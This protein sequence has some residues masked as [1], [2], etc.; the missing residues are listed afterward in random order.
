M[1]KTSTPRFSA[2]QTALGKV[3]QLVRTGSAERD[4][5][6]TI[7]KHLMTCQRHETTG[8]HFSSLTQGRRRIELY[9]ELQTIQKNH[10][11]TSRQS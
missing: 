5:T 4:D 6:V 11:L 2:W 7:C 9:S 10:A 8:D 1:A 3:Y